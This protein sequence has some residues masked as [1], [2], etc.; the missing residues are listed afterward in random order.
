MKIQFKGVPK[1]SQNRRLNIF[2]VN[3]AIGSDKK[4][5]EEN[6]L[7]SPFFPKQGFPRCVVEFENK[8]K[9]IKHETRALPQSDDKL[10]QIAVSKK[11]CQKHKKS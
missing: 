5:I 8:T 9:T 2:K 7:N 1:Q 10:R 4:A 11:R 6:H 3:A